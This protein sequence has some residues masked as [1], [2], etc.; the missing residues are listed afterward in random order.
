MTIPCTS[1]PDSPVLDLP[2]LDL[3]GESGNPVY[4]YRFPLSQKQCLDTPVNLPVKP[5]EEYDDLHP[6]LNGYNIFFPVL[7]LE[8][9]LAVTIN[10]YLR[11]GIIT[12][13]SI[14][15]IF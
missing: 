5:E 1:F 15:D 2:V 4:L 11:K 6:S 13:P 14:F 8:M 9:K 7:V 12:T 3:I 10:P